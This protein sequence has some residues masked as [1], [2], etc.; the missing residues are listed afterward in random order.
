MTI[1]T[2]RIF[3]NRSQQSTVRIFLEIR[4]PKN[5]VQANDGPCNEA[6]DQDVQPDASQDQ[7]DNGQRG[8]RAMEVEKDPGDESDEE[9]DHCDRVVDEADEEDKEGDNG[10]VDSELDSERETGRESAEGSKNSD[11][12]LVVASLG[13]CGADIGLAIGR[14]GGEGGRMGFISVVGLVAFDS[15]SES[16]KPSFGEESFCDF[17]LDKTFSYREGLNPSNILQRVEYRESRPPLPSINTRWSSLLCRPTRAMARGTSQSQASSANSRPNSMA[18]RGSAAAT[19]GMRRRR[20]GAASAG[21]SVSGAGGGSAG[22]GNVLRFYTDDA[23]GL[24]ISP[25]VVLV[26][27]LCFI[28]FVTALHVFGKI[29]RKSTVTGA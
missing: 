21:G 27:S 17:D 11:Q 16:G 4:N 25:T 23:P 22:G 6:R 10:V 19:A 1:R 20:P 2:T 18:P 28:G 12:G 14:R 29:Y 5:T 3:N 8:G 26:M 15:T 13:G 24:K 7:G 9:D